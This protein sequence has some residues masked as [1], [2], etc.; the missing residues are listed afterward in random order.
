MRCIGEMSLGKI[1]LIAALALLLVA[2][3]S[4]RFAAEKSKQGDEM[5]MRQLD[6]RLMMVQTDR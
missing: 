3:G 4:D 5:K 1:S 6:Q 2:C